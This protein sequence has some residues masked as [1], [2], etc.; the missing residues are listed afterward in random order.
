[1]APAALGTLARSQVGGGDEALGGAA[2]L[3]GFAGGG[4]RGAFMVPEKHP[5]RGVSRPIRGPDGPDA[6]SGILA[7]FWEKSPF[8][9]G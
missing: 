5:G 1:M 3:R 2:A 8:P 4:G 9:P 6:R 7:A